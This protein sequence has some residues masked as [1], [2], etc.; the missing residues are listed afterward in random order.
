MNLIN[1]IWNKFLDAIAILG[2]VIITIWDSLCG[3][4]DKE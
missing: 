3:E 1:R 2:L 4:D